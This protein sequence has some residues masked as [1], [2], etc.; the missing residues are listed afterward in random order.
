MRNIKNIFCRKSLLLFDF[1]NCRFRNFRK[2]G[3]TRFI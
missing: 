3:Q 2:W 1:I